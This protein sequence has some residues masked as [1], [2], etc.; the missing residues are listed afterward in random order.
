[1][2]PYTIIIRNTNKS[3]TVH[4]DNELGVMVK[5]VKF[6]IPFASLTTCS[7]YITVVGTTGTSYSFY[8][9]ATPNARFAPDESVT[10]TG[11]NFG[12][13]DVCTVC[14][15]YIGDQTAYIEINS[16]RPKVQMWV[17]A[18]LRDR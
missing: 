15:S 3:A 4:P 8:N 13:N 18:R 1:M 10:V 16:H 7:G 17:P 14:W 12:T 6:S 9:D 2:N 5:D 11:L